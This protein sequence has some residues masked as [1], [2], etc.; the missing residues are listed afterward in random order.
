MTQTEKAVTTLQAAIESRR[1]HASLIGLDVRTH[2][3]PGTT[4]TIIS[5]CDSLGNERGRV[6]EIPVSAENEVI[7]ALVSALKQWQE[8]AR[9]PDRSQ[10]T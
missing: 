10:A 9:R 1:D 6:A 3:R 2:R 4:T 5:W 8:K 7:P